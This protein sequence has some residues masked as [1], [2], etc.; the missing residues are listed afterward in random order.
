MV[1]LGSLGTFGRALVVVRLIRVLWDHSG[2]LWVS[3]GF[4]G[5][6]RARPLCRSVY[7][8]SL[9]SLRCA[10]AVVSFIRV[11]WA[12]SDTLWK[13]SVSF[14]CPWVHSGV[15]RVSSGS[16]GFVVFVRV[17]PGG[18]WVHSCL[19]GSFWCVL[20]VFGFSTVRW[21]ISGAPYGSL[22]SFWFIRVRWILSGLP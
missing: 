3:L 10:L 15:R 21:H 18:H 13:S 22:G 14:G 12:H 11:C 8:G 9:G 2:A 17:R 1:H 16:F 4:V 6:V 19:L 20:G 5:F 7:S